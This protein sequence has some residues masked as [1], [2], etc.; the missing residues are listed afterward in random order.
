MKF[1]KLS[2]C[3]IV[4]VLIFPKFVYSQS[5]DFGIWYGI[6]A[7]FP[8]AKKLDINV[9]TVIRTFNDASKIEQGYLEGEVSYKFSKYL[10]T[11]GSYRII[12]NLED[13]SKFHIRH[14]WFADIKG[15]F[16]LEN[17]LFSV[18]TRFHIQTK[19]YIEN[20]K[21]RIPDYHGRIK[22]KAIY[23]IPKFPVNPYLSVESFSAMFVSSERL[24]DKNRFTIGFE[25]KITKIHS[26]EAEYIF[27]RDYLP[28]LSD[29]HIIS[30]NYNLKF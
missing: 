12:Y 14:K 3:V 22:L 28:H 24:I 6:N 30:I 20:E 23:K 4:I 21:D 17:F 18:R 10:S 29:I 25:Y 19:T 13:D 8:L 5:D 15:S 11:A 27:Q 9:S 26:I 16:P 7:G 1:T 2:I